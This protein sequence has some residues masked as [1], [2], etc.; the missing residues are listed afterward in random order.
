MFRNVFFAA[1][2]VGSIISS[3]LA[4]DVVTV[5]DASFASTVGDNEFVLMEFYAP[6]CEFE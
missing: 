4:E 5:T 2:V 3:A 6:W 1:G